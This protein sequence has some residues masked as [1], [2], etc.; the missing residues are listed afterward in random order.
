M[1]STKLGRRENRGFQNIDI[2]GPQE[3][4]IVDQTS[5]Q[6]LG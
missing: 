1:K 6:N 5:T 3:N 2:E 4:A